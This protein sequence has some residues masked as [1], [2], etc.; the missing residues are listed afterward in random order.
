[1]IRINLLPP[2]ERQPK[3]SLKRIFLILGALAC[4][5]CASLFSCNLF[6]IWHVER[7]ITDARNKYELLM[8]VQVKMVEANG[9]QQVISAKNNMLV[10]LTAERK[11]WHTIITHLGVITP[12]EIWLTEL[13]TVD[14][15]LIKI[16]G[17]AMSYPVL[18]QFI[19]TL[20]QDD[21]FTTPVLLG[22]VLTP[23]AAVFLVKFEISVKFKE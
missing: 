7:Q 19:E 15:N 12:P 2:A 8:P 14:K 11:S 22:A 13:G 18:A 3:W 9:K 16:T 21:V 23:K 5:I 20:E 10:T 17:T 4:F 1:M 6:M